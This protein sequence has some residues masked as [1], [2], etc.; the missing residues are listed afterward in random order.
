VVSNQKGSKRRCCGSWNYWE[1][2]AWNARLG[3]RPRSVRPRPGS[4]LIQ[5]GMGKARIAAARKLEGSLPREI[6]GSY[7]SGFRLFSI[8]ERMR[9]CRGIASSP[10]TFWRG[11]MIARSAPPGAL[12]GT[13]SSPVLTPFLNPIHLARY[14]VSSQPLSDCPR[15]ESHAAADTERR[16]PARLRLLENRDVRD[17]QHLCEFVC[18]QSTPDSFDSVRQ[19]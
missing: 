10:A 13:P 11:R 5:K 4:K 17:C 1:S 2:W 6:S 19:R 16:N 14:L 3:I 12:P 7:P 18:C 15:V 8:T 9:N